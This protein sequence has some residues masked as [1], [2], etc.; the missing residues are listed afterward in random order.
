[1]SI[2]RGMFSRLNRATPTTHGFDV[3]VSAI[4]CLPDGGSKSATPNAGEVWGTMVPWRC[5]SRCQPIAR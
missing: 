3:P 5:D 2:R 4:T 1:M